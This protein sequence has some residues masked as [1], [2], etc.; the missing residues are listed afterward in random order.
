[1]RENQKGVA[2]LLA[3][4]NRLLVKDALLS[5]EEE[6][7]ST[8]AA[9]AAGAMVLHENV[10]KLLPTLDALVFAVDASEIN[11]GSGASTA[12]KYF[13][14]EL[15]LMMDGLNVHN[16]DAPILGEW[17]CMYYVDVSVVYRLAGHLVDLGF[18]CFLQRYC[19]V[20]PILV[21]QVGIRQN[22]QIALAAM[23]ATTKS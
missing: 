15:G 9:A 19:F 13:R 17:V 6:P 16:K 22:G 20:C 18:I 1:M 4:H 14:D 3:A 23:V 21:L 8:E 5:L 2:R 12:M 10:L 7:P 11:N